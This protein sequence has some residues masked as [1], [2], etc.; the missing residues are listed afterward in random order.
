MRSPLNGVRSLDVPWIMDIHNGISNPLFTYTG[1]QA[2]V[3]DENGILRRTPA[4]YPAVEGGAWS[5]TNWLPPTAGTT[6]SISTRKG[7]RTI[8]TSEAFEGMLVEP[9]M[10][11]KCTCVKANP[12]NTTNII[13]GGDAAATLTVVNDIDALTAAGLHKICL[14]NVYK[15]DNSAGTTIA[16]GTII[17]PTVNTNAHSISI[18]A[19]AS[20]GSGSI[21]LNTEIAV[22]FSNSSY[23]R[24]K[25]D[26]IT[27]TSSRQMWVMA[28][29][30]ATVYFIL[31]QLEESPFCTSIIAPAADTAASQTRAASVVSAN[32]SGVFPSTGQ[33]FA[34]FMRVVP[35]INSPVSSITKL[36]GVYTNA[37]NFIQIYSSVAGG[38]KLSKLLASVGSDAGVSS[39]MIAD[40]PTEILCV[41]SAMG[42]SL[43][44]RTFSVTWSAWS[45]WSNN[46]TANAKIAAPITTGYQIGALG[47]T[48]QYPANYPRTAIISMPPKATLAEYQAWIEE[49]LTRRGLI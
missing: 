31:P 38:I 48:G 40:T 32:T 35:D 28:N 19:R 36:F 43:K 45:A 11:N 1:G 21:K 22:E 44:F 10:T 25:A 9:A 33:D 23:E 5:G 26:N 12:T 37:T 2:I 4:G 17:G 49:E 39:T 47:S 20:A 27:P 8:Q 34:I 13:K 29:A 15:L 41:Q 46:I 3:P 14:G 7:L 16:S 24:L 18:Y 42:M 30:G 6:R